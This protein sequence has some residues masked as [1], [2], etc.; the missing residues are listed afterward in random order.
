MAIKKKQR[1][2]EIDYIHGLSVR[3]EIIRPR[4]GG[5]P[6]KW[7]VFNNRKDFET[8]FMSEEGVVP[9]LHDDWRTAPEGGWVEADDGGVCQIIK[10]S[11]M[12]HPKDNG[13]RKIAPHGCVRTVVGTFSTNKHYAMDTDF[14]AHMNRYQFT[15]NPISANYNLSLKHRKHLT[16]KEKIFVANLM[17]YLH[18]GN[19]R[20]E[21]MIMAVNDAG[22]S[23]RDLRGALEKANLLIQQDRIMKL[24]SEQI[25]D[26]AEELGITIKFVLQGVKDLAENARREDVRLSALTK[27]GA[28]LGMDKVEEEMQPGMQLQEGFQGFGKD[29]AL[30]EPEE[31]EVLDVQNMEDEFSQIGGKD[32]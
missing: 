22:F 21:S 10:R 8:Y 27:A 3:Y 9:E 7:M 1:I 25:K 29:R 15:N 12:K 26:T 19:G 16:R 32:E 4:D 28:Y 13:K 14:S 24:I 23:Q 18:Q 5:A 11:S 30:G 6:Q 31:A 20:E 17:M 2:P